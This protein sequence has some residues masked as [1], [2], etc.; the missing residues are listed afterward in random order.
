MALFEENG[1]LAYFSN[2]KDKNMSF[3]C[4][5]DPQ[6]DVLSNR[7][8]ISVSY[9]FSLFSASERNLVPHGFAPKLEHEDKII[10]VRN[11][12]REEFD[13]LGVSKYNGLPCDA[14]F[15]DAIKF[16]LV[17]PNRDCYPVTIFDPYKKTFSVV[18]SGREGTLLNVV[19][20]TATA[21]KKYP[22]SK[23]ED[24]QAYIFPGICGECYKL[25]YLPPGFPKEY[26]QFAR[27]SRNGNI[28]LD[29]RGIIV[30][31]LLEAGIELKRIFFPE[32]E[33]ECTCCTPGP[34]GAK[35]YF[36][37]YGYDKHVPGHE[38][39]GNNM[40]IAEIIYG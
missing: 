5:L 39:P 28:L 32:G 2:R 26:R 33:N 22:W 12:Q 1:L 3:V 4:G 27:S 14:V 38:D 25:E 20:K 31:Q 29:L 7:L 34:N 21:M 17:L 35:K 30:C 6:F 16:P 9:G 24:L 15:S 11:N 37:R 13:G 36:S 8:N 40:L 18:H 19:G 10:C 23:K